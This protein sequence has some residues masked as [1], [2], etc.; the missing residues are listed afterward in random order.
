MTMFGHCR[1]CCGNCQEWTQCFGCCRC[2][3]IRACVTVTSGAMGCSCDTATTMFSVSVTTDDA[4]WSG[5]VTCGDLSIDLAFII[6]KDGCNL[7]LEST[8][9]GLTGVNRAVEPLGGIGQ[10]LQPGD[11][12]LFNVSGA[13]GCGDTDCANLAIAIEP[14]A[15]V[16]NPVCSTCECLCRDVCIRYHE[17]LLASETPICLDATTASFDS[18]TDSWS[19]VFTCGSTEI[20]VEFIVETDEYGNCQIRIETDLAYEVGSDFPPPVDISNCP[21]FQAAGFGFIIDSANDHSAAFSI[22]CLGCS[23]VCDLEVFNCE[24]CPDGASAN[25]KVTISGATDDVCTCSAV[26]AEHT[27]SNVGCVWCSDSFSLCDPSTGYPADGRVCATK[28]NVGWSVSVQIF[29][30]GTWTNIMTWSNSAQSD[31]LELTE[32]TAEMGLSACNWPATIT[33]EPV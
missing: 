18:D 1:N 11:M 31:C 15:L 6:E 4:R 3:P 20:N 2:V 33:I 30:G 17:F 10:C 7:Y 27:V 32:L 8:C 26:N 24:E 22:E 21:T 13:S 12:I 19:A 16:E 14:Y 28:T 29:V 25:Y 23:G 9:L 5:T